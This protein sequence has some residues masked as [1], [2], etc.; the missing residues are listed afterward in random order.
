MRY[1]SW[2]RLA[3]EQSRLGAGIFSGQY[4][5]QSTPNT[6]ELHNFSPILGS[7]F[8]EPLVELKA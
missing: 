5:A 3:K 8:F 2:T 7:H 4:H 1:P 6:K